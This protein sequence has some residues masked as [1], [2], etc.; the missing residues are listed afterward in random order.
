MSYEYSSESGRLDVPN[1]FRV[2]NLFHGVA[3][4]ILLLGGLLLLLVSRGNLQGQLS[5]LSVTPLVI[6]VYLVLHGIG[7]V[8]RAMA[9]LRFFFGRGEPRGLAPELRDDSDSGNR[10]AA[11]I[12]EAMRQNALAFGEPSGALNGLLYS[13]LPHLIFAP[14]PIQMIAQRQFQTAVA[15]AVTLLSFLVAWLGFAKNS[16]SAWLGLFYFLFSAFLLLRPLESGDASRTSLG[17]RGL[18][19]LIL[20]AIFGPVLVPVVAAGLP[21][22]SWLSLNVQTLL[23]LIAAL[24]AVL[25]FFAALTK[26]LVSPP[27][28]TMGCETLTLSFN[29]HPKQL[30]D[31]LE[32]ELQKN[33]VEKIPNRRYEKV[34]PSLNGSS[35]EFAGELLEETQPMP[36]VNLR[37]FDLATCFAQP[38]YLWLGWF[39][40][41]GVALMLTAV[42]SLVLFGVS[43]HPDAVNVRVI[44]FATFGAAML[45]V[46]HFCFKAGHRLWERFDFL[47]ELVWVEMK[48]NHQSAKMDFGNRLTGQ[49]KT[50]KQ[51]TNIETM[52][53]RV[54]VAQI[55][56]VSFGKGAQR[57]LVGMSGLPDKAQ[58]LA[59]HLSRFAGNQSIIVAP[60]AAAD[61]QKVG[62]LGALNKLGDGS[63]ALPQDMQTL[64]PAQAAPNA[65]TRRATDC[66]QCRVTN[67]AHS[68]FCTNCGAALSGHA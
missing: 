25:L 24:G 58:Y 11:A 32:R 53:L 9:R 14:R 39:N 46:A 23:L 31:E 66:D 13:L 16:H 20:V 8:G 54:W 3:G 33:W 12:K 36:A 45:L 52:T 35:G 56:T 57:W 21:D 64:L 30:M 42:V 29:A 51:V 67:D 2:E 43:F 61:M 55:E 34:L 41:L 65:D 18:V 17:V 5:L 38:R 10:Q 63:A 50:E 40:I 22:I 28:T 27:R 62:A 47:S 59:H 60:T 1:P 37:R 6:G 68:L 44:A 49:I 7:Y 48:G 26:Q 4:A 19:I 15:M